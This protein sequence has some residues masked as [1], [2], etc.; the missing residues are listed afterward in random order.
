MSTTKHPNVSVVG[1]GYVGCVLG[2]ALAERGLDVTGIE[3]D[4]RIREAVGAGTSPF[5][6]TGLAELIE[7]ATRNR[8]LRV[9]DDY[10][11]IADADVIIITVGTPLSEDGD[12][13]LTQIVTAARQIANHVADGQLV[14]LKST[15]PP[16][17]TRDVIT[18]ILRAKA[19]VLVA[20]CPERLA[21]G[22]AI[23]DLFAIP[24]VVGGVDEASTRAAADFWHASLAIETIEVESS[25]AAEMVKLADNLWIDLNI[26]MANELA[27]LCD[28]LGGV[29]V[30]EVIAAANTLPK[31]GHHVNILIP[32]MG[33]GGS[34]LTK[35]PWFVHGMGRKLGLELQTPRVSREI[36]DSM[37]SYTVSLIDDF[38]LGTGARPED[39]R[40]AVL[41]L[42]FKDHTG[43]CRHTPTRPF[44]A[45]LAARGYQVAVHDPW[46]SDADA[47][48]VS[49]LEP[50]PDIA[51]AVKDADC[52]TFLTGHRE[53][54]EFP[55]ERLAELAKPGALIVDGRIFFDRDTIR[56]IEALGLHYKGIG[57]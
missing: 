35:D 34:C 23:R 12:A 52:V 17:T 54:K 13:D 45:A 39:C 20:F 4:R 31:V 18:P 7:G 5:N 41:G 29:D 26:A 28:R 25:L 40:V 1:F 33:V 46:V 49:G 21:E 36:N 44:I 9:T 32:S 27:K 51:A 42:A 3:S 2:A 14:I 8:R 37:P 57:R 10:E 19:D 47:R 24:V 53:F 15:V 11:A 38:L 6:E 22:Q 43:D 50:E 56:H 30:L 55:L 48:D 16:N